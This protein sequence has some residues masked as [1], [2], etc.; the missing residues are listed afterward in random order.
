MSLNEKLRGIYEGFIKNAPEEVKAAF[1]RGAQEL[2]ESKLKER[3]LK[4]GEKMP[5]FELK[6]AVGKSIKSHELLKRGPLV[7]SFYRGSW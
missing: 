4:V 7:I 1:D 6:N 3:A 5:S 2:A